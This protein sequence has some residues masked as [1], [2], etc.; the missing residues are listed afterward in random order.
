[1]HPSAIQ[2]LTGEVSDMFKIS[3]TR[4]APDGK[5]PTCNLCHKPVE[6]TSSKTDGDGKAVHEECY[7]HLVQSQRRTA[8]VR[9][10]A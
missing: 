2:G 8:E 10:K 9:P 4:D 5:G 1:M 7:V 6:L 3:E